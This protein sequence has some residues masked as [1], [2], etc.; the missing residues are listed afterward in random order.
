[1][2]M[3][4]LFCFTCWC[5]SDGFCVRKP[6][7]SVFRAGAIGTKRINGN[8]QGVLPHGSTDNN[9]VIVRRFHRDIG[10]SKMFV[11]SSSS[12]LCNL[13]ERAIENPCRISR[14]A[15]TGIAVQGKQPITRRFQDE[16]IPVGCGRLTGGRSGGNLDGIVV[17]GDSYCVPCMGIGGGGR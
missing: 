16:H 6:S 15:D 11:R 17:C 5:F 12:G 10:K 14:R 7:F 8:I 13:P 3:T 4:P 1:M 2:A 9:G